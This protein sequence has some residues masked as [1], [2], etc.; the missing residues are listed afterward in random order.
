[1]ARRYRELYGRG[2]YLPQSYQHEVAARVRMATRRHGLHRA[3]PGEARSVRDGASPFT[4]PNATDEAPEHLTTREA[5]P[6]Q[7]T[8]M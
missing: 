3:E 2:S 8:L 7:L 6:E 1:L 5:H 4:T